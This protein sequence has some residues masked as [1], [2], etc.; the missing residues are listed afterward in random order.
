[1]NHPASDNE[2]TGLPVLRTWGAVYWF[3]LVAFVVMVGL[4]TVLTRVFS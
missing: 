1:M 4:L 2:T 3:V